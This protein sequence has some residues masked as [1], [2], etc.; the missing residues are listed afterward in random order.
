M[1]LMITKPSA[2]TIK[3]EHLE[4]AFE[5]NSHGAGFSVATGGRVKTF[6]PYWKFDEFYRDYIVWELAMTPILIHFRLAT[7]GSR[8]KENTHPHQLCDR[9]SMAHNGII[10]KCKCVGDESDTRAFIRENVKP[11][12]K[13]DE[14]RLPMGATHPA[15]TEDKLKEYDDLIGA[16]KLAFLNAAGMF[17]HVNKKAGHEHEGCWWSNDSYKRDRY[18]YTQSDYVG[19]Q[20][21]RGT[22]FNTP[23]DKE[24]VFCIGCGY[25]HQRRNTVRSWVR[26][27]W[28]K[29][30]KVGF[31]LCVC[32]DCLSKEEIA[33]SG[34]T[35]YLTSIPPA[36]QEKADRELQN[37]NWFKKMSRRAESESKQYFAF[38]NWEVDCS[39]CGRKA[40]RGAVQG[41]LPPKDVAGNGAQKYACAFC[42][43]KLK[44]K[45]YNPNIPIQLVQESPEWKAMQEVASWAAT[46]YKARIDAEEVIAASAK[47]Q[48]VL[49]KSEELVARA[50]RMW[51]TTPNGTAAFNLHS[52]MLS[53]GVEPKTDL[54]RFVF[55]S[56]GP[57]CI[58]CMQ[59]SLVTN[60]MHLCMTCAPKFG[61]KKDGPPSNDTGVVTIGEKRFVQGSDRLTE[62]PNQPG[63]SDR[64]AMH[65][66]LTQSIL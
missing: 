27:D 19:Y 3:R 45:S 2:V 31:D 17:F 60:E 56:A 48:E 32:R 64:E 40:P 21:A 49:T 24:L 34:N 7:H 43:G 53:E 10:T 36:F 16:S 9:M 18:T 22:Q 13:I 57:G 38:G 50:E 42:M 37:L 66:R 11:L 5:N 61:E 26:P 28:Q 4:K 23:W 39:C 8:N 30:I 59:Q 12:I 33:L 44:H 14:G 55:N 58:L 46:V 51:F 41:F 29:G 52:L 15:V 62:I 20:Y 63:W 35:T 6:K 65:K 54:G 1:C 47:A 25:A